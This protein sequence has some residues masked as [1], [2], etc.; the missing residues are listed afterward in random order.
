MSNPHAA[1]TAAAQVAIQQMMQ[2]GGFQGLPPMSAGLPGQTGGFQNFPLPP[3][4]MQQ[5]GGLMGGPINLPQLPGGQTFQFN[6]AQFQQFQQQ[7][8]QKPMQLPPTM[9]QQMM[10][11]GARLPV[12]QQAP[13]MQQQQRPPQQ[14]A[15]QQ[16]LVAAQSMAAKQ[17]TQVPLVQTSIPPQLLDRVAGKARIASIAKIFDPDVE[18]EDDAVE[19]SEFGVHANMYKISSV[20]AIA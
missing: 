11:A 16:L 15:P 13:P 14:V 9:A 17:P 8:G 10:Q 1:A 2:G 12:P 5:L 3:V 19:V 6:A 7:Q 4:D 18:L 20:S